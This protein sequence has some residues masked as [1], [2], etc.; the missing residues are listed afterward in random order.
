[1]NSLTK[2]SILEKLRKEKDFLQTEFGVKSIG[3]FGSYLENREN[4]KSDIDI[5][6]RFTNPNFNNYVNLLK[7]LE[8]T[9]QKKIDLYR[10]KDKESSFQKR[11][12]N[13]VLYAN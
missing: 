2:E 7:Y 13:K 9:F 11:I 3:L 8:K 5:A 10:L 6:V 12:E 1:M 4:S